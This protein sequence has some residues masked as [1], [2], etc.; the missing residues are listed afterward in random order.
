MQAQSGVQ[1]TFYQRFIVNPDSVVAILSVLTQQHISTYTFYW[2]HQRGIWG[3]F[4]SSDT[5]SRSPFWTGQGHFSLVWVYEQLVRL[6]Y[7][8]ARSNFER[9]GLMVAVMKLKEFSA[10]LFD[11][12][13]Q[14]EIIRFGHAEDRLLLQDQVSTHEQSPTPDPLNI[15]YGNTS[16][17]DVELGPQVRPQR[18][19][20]RRR[21]PRGQGLRSKTGCLSCRRSH[22]KCDEQSGSCGRCRKR[23]VNCVYPSLP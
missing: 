10:R 8:F 13:G 23:N 17:D 12:F 15:D 18:S 11:K 14:S 21:T 20:K 6:P 3:S 5:T 16:T 1:S 4:G 7:T 19:P 9:A 22:I 2:S